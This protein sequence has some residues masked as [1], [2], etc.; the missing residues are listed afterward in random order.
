MLISKK[1]TCRQK[2]APYVR[3]LLH[4]GK[5]G[6]EIGTLLSIAPVA[7]VTNG[8]AQGNENNFLFYYADF[9]IILFKML[10]HA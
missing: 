2:Y 1:V 4:G 9:S 7:A 5:S 3:D 8:P 10:A 6:L